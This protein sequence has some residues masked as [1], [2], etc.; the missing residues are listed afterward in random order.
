MKK[1]YISFIIVALILSHAACA[2][3]AYAWCSLEWAAKYE[4][5]SAPPGIS[6]IYAIPFAALVALCIALALYFKKKNK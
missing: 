4:G 1:A 6:L 5:A 3:I 2:L